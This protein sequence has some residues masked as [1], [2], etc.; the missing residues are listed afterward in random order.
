MSVAL[1]APGKSMG[2]GGGR[3][4]LWQ[5]PRSST[6]PSGGG[7]TNGLP[8]TSIAGLSGWWDAGDASTAL[9]TTG[10]PVSGW[11]SSTA[12]LLNK[13]G[14][15]ALTP[16]SFATPAGL[17]TTTPRL[18]GLLG[19]VGRIAGGSGTL[20]PA[21]DPDMGFQVANVPLQASAS[22]TRYFV[23]S[24]PNWRQNSGHDGNPVTLLSSD[25][26]PVLQA[27]SA[28]GQNRLLL[29]PGNLS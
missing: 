17:P 10:A 1:I 11:N 7:T 20:A 26:T 16:Y 18:S 2:I 27:D 24:R 14:G 23:W 8:P 6:A 3:L 21:L 15:I 4:A 29:F 13:A 5:A 19:G 12:S 28:S 25:S 9:G 22:W